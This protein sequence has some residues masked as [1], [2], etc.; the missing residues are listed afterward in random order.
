MHNLISGTTT[1][2]L[3]MFTFLFS[4]DLTTYA[5][6]AG[7]VLV[8]IRIIGDVPRVINAWAKLFKG[9]DSDSTTE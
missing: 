2:G 5:A 6:L 1:Y 3:G 4:Q 7:L 8:V 9:G